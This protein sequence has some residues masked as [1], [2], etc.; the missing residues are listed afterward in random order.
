M[1]LGLCSQF[2][3]CAYHHRHLFPPSVHKTHNTMRGMVFY[4]SED[5]E[6][7]T[8]VINSRLRTNRFTF[9]SFPSLPSSTILRLNLEF[10]WDQ[11]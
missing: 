4:E 6:K 7:T 10:N 5:E 8:L 3:A 11:V 1:G 9:H 2:L